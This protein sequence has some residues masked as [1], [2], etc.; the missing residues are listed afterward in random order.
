[1]RRWLIILLMP[2]VFWVALP[3]WLKT[4]NRT[5]FPL[6]KIQAVSS[7]TALWFLAALGLSVMLCLLIGWYLNQPRRLLILLIV[8]ISVLLLLWVGIPRWRFTDKTEPT[9]I[10]LQAVND[11]A[12]GWLVVM[13]AASVLGFVLMGQQLRAIRRERTSRQRL[14][15]VFNDQ[16]NEGVA[17]FSVSRSQPQLQWIN[18]AGLAYFYEQKQLNPEVGRLLQ[19][20]IES[21]H[22]TAQSLSLGEGTRV[23]IQVTPLSENTVSVVARS[24]QSDADTSSF[25]ENFIR[26]IVHDMRNPLAAVIAHASN[27]YLAPPGDTTTW[28][29]TARTI[30]NEAQRLTRLVDSMLFD[31]RLAFVPI[32]PEKID[33]VDVIEDVMFQHDERANREG[34]AIEIETPSEAVTVQA[35]RDLLVR[36]L[37]NLVDN[38]LKYSKSGAV[39]L[40]RLEPTPTQ[41]ILKVMDN[42]DGIPPDYLPDKIF[43]PLVRARPRGEHSGSGLGLSIVK[44]I[45]E[46]HGG[47]IAVQ[48]VVGKGTTMTICLPR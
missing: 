33:L 16:I 38:S 8:G 46:L 10:V 13:S 30:E 37:S 9:P 12:Q 23:T 43:D 47:T 6:V 34:K 3:L 5:S 41:T 39:V 20:T 18:A 22:I 14:I 1:M 45:V 36:A 27:L 31:A 24:L 26:R 32:A 19:R 35:D 4:T 29:N 25:Y 17:I 40:I 42:G 11:T 21:Q 7:S 28:Q 2:L 44:K 48:S 15:T